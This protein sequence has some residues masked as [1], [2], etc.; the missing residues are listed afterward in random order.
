MPPNM[1]TLDATEVAD[2]EAP[3]RP[4]SPDAI[5][6][7]QQAVASAETQQIVT[8]PAD[9]PQNKSIFNQM[10]QKLEKA[11][12]EVTA[13]KVAE[14]K[15]EATETPAKAE[16]QATESKE[17][18]TFTSAKAADWKKLKADREEW[19][20]K[21]TE[22]EQKHAAT[23]KELEAIRAKAISTDPNP[24]LQ[25]QLDELRTEKEKYLQQL[26]TVALERSER[27]SSAFQKVFDASL[28]RAKEAAGTN[29]EKVEHLIQ[30]PPSK[31]RKE[32]IQEVAETLPDMDR[33][34][35]SMAI[36][37][38]DRAR[39]DRDDALKNSRENLKKVQALDAERSQRE[40]QLNAARVDAAIKSVMEKARSREA[41][42][43]KE[44]QDAHNASVKA[45]EMEVERFLRGQMS[46]D[47]IAEIPLDAIEGRRLRSVVVPDLQKR[48]AEAEAALKEYQTATPGTTGPVSK[49][50][51]K[52]SGGENT[53]ERRPFMDQFLKQLGT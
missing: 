36:T 51:A 40:Q 23:V 13:P 19:Q 32:R 3:V 2:M 44:G 22:L 18:E 42:Q 53:G 9:A 50:Q 43:T 8:H 41:F 25:K 27:F 46:A 11:M 52:P 4:M 37:E 45:N 16:A 49:Q 6:K 33:A 14:A 47:A 38:Y 21:A 35:L 5:A 30:L 7:Q 12:Q 10:S 48:L 26:E 20:K 39:A 29:A 31:W 34:A 1:E 28:A 15:P 17:P 24:E